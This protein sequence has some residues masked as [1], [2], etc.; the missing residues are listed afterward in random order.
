M[1]LGGVEAEPEDD[2]GA[3]DDSDVPLSSVIDDA[4]QMAILDIENARFCGNSLVTKA[5]GECLRG[6]GPNKDIWSYRDDG[7]PWLALEDG[8]NDG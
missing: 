3:F 7:L 8:S 1:D 6:E 2:D 4:L 5:A